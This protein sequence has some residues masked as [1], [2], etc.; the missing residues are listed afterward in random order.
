M[1]AT[2]GDRL[3]IKGHRLGEHGRDALILAVR[4]ERGAPPYLVRWEDDGHE[5]LVFPGSD[6]EVHHYAGA[7]EAAGAARGGDR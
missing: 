6:A 4:G 3:I 1:Q 5:S 7:G 2:A